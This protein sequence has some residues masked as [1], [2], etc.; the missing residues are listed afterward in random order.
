MG[1]KELRAIFGKN[2]KI[3]R[4]RRN[5]SQSDLAE[6]ADISLNFLGDIERGKKWPHP[7]TLTKLA[8]ALEIKVFELFMEEDNESNPKT[9]NSMNRF[10]KDVS[11]TINKTLSLSIKQS[12]EYIRKQ[13]KLV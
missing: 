13:Y 5:W 3:Y 7:E 12:I 9:K 8:A 4:N 1:G 11:L 10:I 2:V 6:Y